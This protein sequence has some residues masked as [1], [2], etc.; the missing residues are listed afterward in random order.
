[1]ALNW[2]G[3][4]KGALTGLVGGGLMSGGTPAG[5]AGGAILG[6]LGGLFSGD[7]GSG[8]AGMDPKWEV[9]NL[10][11]YDFTEPRFRSMSDFV[12]DQFDSLGKGEMPVWLKNFLYGGVVST[13]GDAVT[14]VPGTWNTMNKEL[15][16][17]YYGR[18]GE[19][20]GVVPSA[21]SAAAITG[22]GAGT[23]TR[24]VS[25][26]LSEYKDMASKIDEFISNLGMSGTLDTMK[27]AGTIGLGIPQGP[28]A[29]VVGPYG[30]YAAQPQQDNSGLMS[31]LMSGV[32]PLA[33]MLGSN[34]IN[35][36]GIDWNAMNSGTSIAGTDYTGIRNTG[37]IGFYNESTPAGSA[38]SASSSMY[39]NA[40]QD[41]AKNLLSGY[42]GYGAAASMPSYFRP[43]QAGIAGLA[44]Y[45]F[46]K[47][48][49]G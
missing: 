42:S 33:S 34:V 44:Q 18:P 27:T 8:F 1:M 4:G 13:A 20:Y 10:P 15:E 32:G 41:F 6:G 36:N 46:N 2:G 31:S 38:A 11:T 14:S 26:K 17:T 30:G 7:E 25:R 19:R 12:K 43:A 29:V 35:G 3:A 5:I 24:Q 21:L 47:F 23:A 9:V 40:Y 48:L 49:G 45:G 16:S 28:P 22:A 37:P 39:N